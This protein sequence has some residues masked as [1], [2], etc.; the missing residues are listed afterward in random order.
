MTGFLPSLHGG[1]MLGSVPL[2]HF[3]TCA[4]NQGA[5][6]RLDVEEGFRPEGINP[7]ALQGVL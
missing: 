2:M 1:T 4:P 6:G 3:S 7:L 5:L